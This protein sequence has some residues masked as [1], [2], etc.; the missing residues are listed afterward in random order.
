MKALEENSIFKDKELNKTSVNK[1][2]LITTASDEKKY[3]TIRGR[4]K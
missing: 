2:S 1:D 4:Y 3:K